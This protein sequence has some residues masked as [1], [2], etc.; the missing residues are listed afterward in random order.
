[1]RC[2]SIATSFFQFHGRPF[3]FP[4]PPHFLPNF[5]SERDVDGGELDCDGGL[6]GGGGYL[7]V[8]VGGK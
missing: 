5:K 4:G 7:V 3:P 6:N 2:L 1:M 8:G